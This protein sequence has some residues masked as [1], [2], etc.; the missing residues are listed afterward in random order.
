[1]AFFVKLLG[2]SKMVLAIRVSNVFWAMGVLLVFYLLLEK[3]IP[4][5]LSFLTTLLMGTSVWFLNFSRNGWFNLSAVFFGLLMIYFLERKP[6]DQK[7]KDIF[8]AGFFAGIPCYGYFAGKIFP[9]AASI[10]FVLK[11]I[12]RRKNLLEEIKKFVIFL[13]ALTITLT[14]LIFTANR[15]RE[16]FFRRPAA[17]FIL[18]IKTPYYG[19]QKMG[20]ILIYQTKETIKGLLFGEG[21]SIGKG[22]ENLRYS[23]AKTSLVDPFI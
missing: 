6:K 11:I 16:T 20:D 15:Q 1:M 18:N 22:A 8:L 2:L 23:P 21:S 14:P 7:S 4:S 19:Y 5:Q 9:L 10:W 17:T 13:L 3:K 12:L